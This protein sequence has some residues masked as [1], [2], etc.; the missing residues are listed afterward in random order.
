VVCR[1]AVWE[2]DLGGGDGGY[3]PRY[4]KTSAC[5]DAEV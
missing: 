5:V 2:V 3:G 1:E 4:G